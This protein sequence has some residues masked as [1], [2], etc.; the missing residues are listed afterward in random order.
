MMNRISSFHNYQSVSN[1]MMKQQVRIQQNQDQLASGKRVLTAGD[2][3]VSSIYIQNFKQQNTQIDQY[4]DSINL[5]RN[6]QARE[7]I[8]IDN[9]EQLVDSAKRTSLAMINGALSEDDR[10]AHKQE[11][12]G[13]FDNFMN[14]VNSKDESGNY[15]FAGTRTD[16]Q[17]FFR[18][19]SGDVTYVGDSYHRKS[20]IAASL[21]VVTSDPGDK[22]F[23]D[24]DNP[25]GN[26]DPTYD[27]GDDST[28]LLSSAV[29]A[30]NSDN[31]AY[32]ISFGADASGNTTYELFQNGVSV[33]AGV[34]DPQNGVNWGTLS[35]QVEGNIESGDSIDLSRQDTFSVFESFKHAMDMSDKAPD[36]ASA[37]AELHKVTEQLAGAFKHLNQARSDVGIRLQTMDRQEE[38]H[39]DFKVDL[40]RSLGTME[41]LDYSKAVIELNENMLALQASQQAFSKAKSL[42][43]FNYM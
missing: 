9:A 4:L 38:T 29:N 11:L 40:N 39:Q 31:A 41:D 28:L 16:A 37:T 15:L 14:L 35:V 10:E 8:A 6:R 3:P 12:K 21:D 33:D 23:M 19:N 36:D 25:F 24:I 7:E 2:D 18:N 5:A 1:D 34:Y 43:L 26:Y 17:P 30:N 42:S 20:Q 27:L 32:E 22:V 13:I